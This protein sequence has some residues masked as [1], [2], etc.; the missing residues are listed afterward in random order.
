MKATKACS[1]HP[2]GCAI[3]SRVIRDGFQIPTRR[4]L[5]AR[6]PPA[7]LLRRASVDAGRSMI[8]RVASSTVLGTESTEK[9]QEREAGV[10]DPR[11]RGV[12]YGKDDG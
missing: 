5:P 11:R 3:T 12:A 1:P 6:P 8:K 9:P 2:G 7:W 4:L 10:D